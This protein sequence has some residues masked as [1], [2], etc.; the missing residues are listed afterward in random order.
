MSPIIG[1]LIER[2]QPKVVYIQTKLNRL[3]WLNL[4]SCVCV[5]VIT[6]EKKKIYLNKGEWGD[7]RD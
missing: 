5:C 7:E 4:Y 6:K 3:R 1:Y 2:G